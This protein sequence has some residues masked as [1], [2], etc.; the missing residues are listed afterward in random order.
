MRRYSDRRVAEEELESLKHRLHLGDVRVRHWKAIE[1]LY[2]SPMLAFAFLVLFAEYVSAKRK[3]LLQI[4]YTTK[5]ELDPNARF[6]YY[7]VLD[8]LQMASALSG[9]KIY[10]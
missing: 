9:L 8:V 1:H 5:S 2:L 7:R 3:G 6:T 10:G 4:L